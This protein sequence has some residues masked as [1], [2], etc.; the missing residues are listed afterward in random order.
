MPLAQPWACEGPA[1][2]RERASHS[3]LSAFAKDKQSEG[4]DLSCTHKIPLVLTD[5][6]R[7]D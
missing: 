2:S 3:V 1:D 6:N 4:Q 7:S 5:F